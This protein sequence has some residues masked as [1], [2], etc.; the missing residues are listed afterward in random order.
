MTAISP[1]L[2]YAVSGIF[3]WTSKLSRSSAG[4]AYFLHRFGM[5]EKELVSFGYV[6]DG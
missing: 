4:P 6:Y 2:P 3:W 1:G 5:V